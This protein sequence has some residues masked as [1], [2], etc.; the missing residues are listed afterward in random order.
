MEAFWFF[1][2]FHIMQ[3]HF[4][5]VHL[6]CLVR[7]CV[8]LFIAIILNAWWTTGETINHH[9]GF[10]KD[11]MQS[12]V[13]TQCQTQFSNQSNTFFFARTLF[14]NQPVALTGW[15]SMDGWVLEIR[16]NFNHGWFN[17]TWTIPL[18]L[19][20]SF[21]DGGWLIAAWALW[22][23]FA[24]MPGACGFHWCGEASFQK[25]NNDNNNSNPMTQKW[26]RHHHATSHKTS[27][28]RSLRQWQQAEQE[29]PQKC[30]VLLITKSMAFPTRTSIV[31]VAPLLIQ[32]LLGITINNLHR[33]QHTPTVF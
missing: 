2:S 29:P 25:S 14:W 17:P 19:I 20:R 26:C 9:H 23:F 22:C 3:L 32:A 12:P 11:Q 4:L 7:H 27:D 13:Q 24:K 6:T 33:Q 28:C 1:S 16:I 18:I 15:Q 10:Q 21:N 5:S 31:P 30:I 8:V